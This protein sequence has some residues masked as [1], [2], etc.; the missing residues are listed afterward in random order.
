MAKYTPPSGRAPV[1]LGCPNEA[2]VRVTRT[3]LIVDFPSLSQPLY[4]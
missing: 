4:E 2:G 1:L 3:A